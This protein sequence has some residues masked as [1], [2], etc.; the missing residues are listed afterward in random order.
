MSRSLWYWVI[1]VAL[2]LA[3]Y[4][5]LELW[6]G[7][8]E[9]GLVTPQTALHPGLLLLGVVT[10]LLR[11]YVIVLLPP[12]VTYHGVLALGGWVAP[13][14][15]GQRT[16]AGGAGSSTDG[17]QGGADGGEGYRSE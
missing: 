8:Q 1:G 11:L 15:R 4:P 14:T 13:K 2:P 6:L 5:L 9:E 12:W 7:A 16:S 10:L 3:L 17:T